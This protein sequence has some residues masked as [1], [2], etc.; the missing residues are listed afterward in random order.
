MLTNKGNLESK[1][2]TIHLAVRIPM[3]ERRFSGGH[4][5]QDHSTAEPNA[6]KPLDLPERQYVKNPSAGEQESHTSLTSSHAIAAEL[7][8]PS[9]W[10]RNAGY[11]RGDQR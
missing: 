7:L 10:Q 3:H 11:R 6:T 4:P 5:A 2:C 1:D 9:P 8:S